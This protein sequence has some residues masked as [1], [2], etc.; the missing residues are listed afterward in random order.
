MK[1]AKMIV[2]M[3]IGL[4]MVGCGNKNPVPNRGGL[5]VKAQVSHYTELSYR[6][7]FLDKTVTLNFVNPSKDDLKTYAIQNL[8]SEKCAAAASN[9]GFKVSL[10]DPNCKDCVD[11][12]AMKESAASF[13]QTNQNAPF[14][15]CLFDEKR[16]GQ[17]CFTSA[18]KNMRW[19]GLNFINR[20][21]KKS[22]HQMEIT[23]EGAANSVTKV[24]AEMCY[25]GFLNF[26]DAMI[27]K[28]YTVP[29]PLPE[30]ISSPTK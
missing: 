8:I 17:N 3:G 18:T 28:D 4:L 9:K 21:T 30:N 16:V 2:V 19:M 11:V 14:V 23:S 5:V 27:K 22:V 25:A 12:V 10:D 24:A 26:P 6:K 7:A 1:N 29:F 13:E 20:E 15:Q